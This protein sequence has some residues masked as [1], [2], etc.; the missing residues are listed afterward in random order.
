MKPDSRPREP[1]FYGIFG[2][3]SPRFRALL[4]TNNRRATAIALRVHA[5][6]KLQET[7]KLKMKRKTG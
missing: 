6:R 7:Q 1:F 3:K 4:R 2:G 5:L